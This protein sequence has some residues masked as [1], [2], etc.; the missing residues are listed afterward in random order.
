MNN[1]VLYRISLGIMVAALLIM[2]MNW[3]LLP[4]PDSVVRVI[5]VGM[6]TD[7]VFLSYLTAK[8]KKK[9]MV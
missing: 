7:L 2:G 4:L 5:G 3:L 6:M 9:S 8:N 1:R